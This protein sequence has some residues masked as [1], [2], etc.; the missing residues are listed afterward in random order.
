MDKRLLGYDPLTKVK[1]YHYYDE[2]NDLTH[3][4]SVQDIT[5]II[6]LNKKLHNTDFQRKGIKD[7]WM[8]GAHI[9]AIIQEKWLREFGIDILNKDHMPAVL[10]KLNDPDWKYLKSGSCKL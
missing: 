3:I 7:C 4:E 2:V 9:P 1:T 10:K 5:P 8:H 6:E